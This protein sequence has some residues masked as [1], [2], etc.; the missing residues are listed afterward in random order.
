MSLSL[1]DEIKE[2]SIKEMLWLAFIWFIVIALIVSPI[3]MYLV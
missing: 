3:A 1:I 2:K